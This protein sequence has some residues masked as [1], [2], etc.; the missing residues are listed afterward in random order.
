MQRPAAPAIEAPPVVTPISESSRRILWIVGVY[1][2][3]CGAALLGTALLLDLKV[4]G[5]AAP[6]AFAWAAALYFVFGLVTFVWIQR[7]PIGM[8]LPRLV[9]SLLFGDVMCIALVM[10][11]GGGERVTLRQVA[12][13]SPQQGNVSSCRRSRSWMSGPGSSINSPRRQGAAACGSRRW[14]RPILER[15][16]S[17]SF[18][19]WEPDPWSFLMS[20]MAAFGWSK[21]IYTLALQKPCGP[22]QLLKRPFRSWPSRPVRTRT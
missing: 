7:D 15:A 5:I 17:L 18:W 3:I 13:V 12:R 22:G 16:M 9:S 1:R 19:H 4:L 20:T 21:N 6:N 14:P 8:P 10:I 11:A 2:A